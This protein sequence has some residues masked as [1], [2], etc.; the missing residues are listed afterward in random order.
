VKRRSS[1]PRAVTVR[2][3]KKRPFRSLFHARAKLSSG[4]VDDFLNGILG[5]ADGLLGFA[6]ALLQGAFNLK[7]GVAYGLSGA[8]LDRAGGSLAIP[9]IL[10]VVLLIIALLAN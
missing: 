8:P 2:V 6:L 7:V 10:S 1:S 3:S 9:L 4:L 5:L